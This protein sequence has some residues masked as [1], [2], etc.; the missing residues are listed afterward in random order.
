MKTTQQFDGECRGCGREL[1]LAVPRGE[2]FVSRAG[3][4]HRCRCGA[5]TALK[6]AGTDNRFADER[7]LHTRSPTVR[8]GDLEGDVLA[9]DVFISQSWNYRAKYHRS[10]ACP[11]L[12]QNHDDW[13]D[14][15]PELVDP[16][17]TGCEHHH[18]WGDGESAASRC[19]ICGMAVP[20]SQVPDH[21]VECIGGDGS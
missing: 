6:P 11:R 14:I 9:R 7:T 4:R 13:R 19:P 3:V 12:Q 21:I 10:P 1:S 16:P 2:L 18:C 8:F 15:Q 17:H 20:P 5:T